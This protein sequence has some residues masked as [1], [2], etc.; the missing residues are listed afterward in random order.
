[1]NMN[2]NQDVI[3]I[4]KINKCKNMCLG[5]IKKRNNI[6]NKQKV[7]MNLNQD[8]I[9]YVILKNVKMSYG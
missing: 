5:N 2:F 3:K 1:M 8:V 6:K 4:R 9:K 7:Y